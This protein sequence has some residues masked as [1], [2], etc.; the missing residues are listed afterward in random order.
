MAKI[1]CISFKNN[2]KHGVAVM[3]HILTDTYRD[4]T[5]FI[6][7]TDDKSEGY[8]CKPISE[9]ERNKIRRDA[10][11]EAGG[12]SDIAAQIFTIKFLQRSITDWKGFFDMKGDA[13]PCNEETIAMICRCD[14][15]ICS[16]LAIKVMNIARYGELD[17]QKN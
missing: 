16:T 14:P 3:P 12:D 2:N 11:K 10:Q 13:I 6:A 5:F 15:D 1:R 9:T 4:K 7:L 17:D 8:W